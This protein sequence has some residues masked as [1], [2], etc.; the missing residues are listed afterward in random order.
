MPHSRHH[1]LHLDAL[2]S[3]LVLV[4]LFVHRGT[5]PVIDKTTSTLTGSV[6]CRQQDQDD[7]RAQ[8][9]V[10]CALALLDAIGEVGRPCCPCPSGTGAC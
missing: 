6:T 4:P 2:C 7:R 1:T 10:Q 8:R 9:A 3:S 5:P